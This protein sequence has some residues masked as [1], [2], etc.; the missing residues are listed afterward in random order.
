L[1]DYTTFLLPQFVDSRMLI[2]WITSAAVVLFL[3]FFF[4]WKINPMRWL[5]NFAG[6]IC[7]IALALIPVAYFGTPFYNTKMMAD[8][9]AQDYGV[10]VSAATD[11]KDM[12]VLHT[13]KALK[14]EV[15]STDLVRY[16]V[17]CDVPEGKLL[18]NDITS[19]K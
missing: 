15:N 7:L 6:T 10:T 1:E 18:L 9:V 19:R 2:V 11:Y 13:D 12:I 8:S 4:I 14:C 16:Y 17:L 3:L 5:A